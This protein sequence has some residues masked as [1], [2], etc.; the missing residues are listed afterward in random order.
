MMF[1]RISGEA[2]QK[3]IQPPALAGPLSANRVSCRFEPAGGKTA[4][5]PVVKRFAA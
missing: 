3:F 4:I 5:P 1:R 2:L